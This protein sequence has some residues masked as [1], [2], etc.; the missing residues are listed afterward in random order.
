[1]SDRAVREPLRAS[2]RNG[3][4][5]AP[6]ARL[7]DGSICIEV[8]TTSGKALARAAGDASSLRTGEA[9]AALYA[10]A[11]A[12]VLVGVGGSAS[13]DG[14]TGIARAH[15]WRFLDANDRELPEGGA[16]LVD[17]AEIDGRAAI[18]P[19]CEIVGLCDVA[20]PLLG[21]FGAARTFGP[22]KGASP[23]E[24]EVLEDGLG[25][26]AEIV[27]SRLGLD[28]A[29]PPM[30]GAGGGIG[31]GLAAFLGARLQQGFAFISSHVG[32]DLAIEGSD[33]VITGEGALDAG[34]LSGKVTGGVARLARAASVPCLAVCGR[35]DLNEDE[36]RAMGFSGWREAV[37]REGSIAALEGPARSLALAAE[38]AVEK[39]GLSLG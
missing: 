38:R 23:L 10:R 13:T 35:I 8:A 19:P 14:G 11:P 3:E 4:F 28:I 26:L 1:M 18:A 27:S 36:L 29:T 12:R 32:A 2:G 25:R 9:T 33:L 20:N 24:V 17:L 5:E 21:A 31:A 30:Y 16:A 6:A 37:G 34:S 39:W 7:A 22:Q 15:G